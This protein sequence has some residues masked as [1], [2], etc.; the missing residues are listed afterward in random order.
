MQQPEICKAV[1]FSEGTYNP[2]AQMGNPEVMALFDDEM[3]DAIQFDTLE[4]ELARC[5][6]FDVV[7]SYDALLAAYV[8]ARRG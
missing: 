8:A 1:A 6:E 7:P 5:V 3:L 2:I 4:A